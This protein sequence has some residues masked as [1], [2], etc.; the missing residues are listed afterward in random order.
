MTNVQTQPVTQKEDESQN[1]TLQPSPF[2]LYTF[3]RLLLVVA[4]VGAP[5]AFG[6]VVPWAWMALGLVACLALLLWAVGSVQQGALKLVWTPLYLP[7]ALFFILALFQYLGGRTLDRAETRQALVLLA[8]DVALFF[9]AIQLSSTAS[10]ETWRA[11]GLTVLMLAGSLGLFAILQFAAGEQQIYGSVDT[12]GNLLFGPYVNPNHFAGLME[13]LIPVGILYI[14]ERRGKPKLAI[15]A[16]LSLG[17]AVAVASLLL[18]GSRGGLLALGAEVVIAVAVLGRRSA[19]ASPAV[20]PASHLR[21]RTRRLGSGG[22]AALVA[23][24]ILAAVLLFTW[25]DPGFVAQKLGLIVDVGGP[26]W[27]EWAEFR[28]TV[29][30]DSLRMLRDHPIT[31]VGLGNFETAYPPYQSFP[32]E[33]WIDYAHN[34]YV[35]AVAET[36]LVGG[37]LILLALALFL[38]QAFIPTRLQSEIS[39]DTI[40]LEPEDY[41]EGSEPVSRNSSLA[42]GSWIRLGASL[43]CCGMLVHSFFDFNL[44]IPANAAWFAVLAGLA[45]GR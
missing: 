15:L 34:D 1:Y 41:E 44:H 19:G 11:F 14:A 32:S 42:A 18:S 25:V 5:L 37:A 33:L 7:L 13:M 28:K 20:A 40:N 29:A 23:A 21:G 3:C 2:T 9:L 31:G 24:T 12:P 43:G 45:V 17:A 39:N 30:S 26:A 22:L 35:Q 6:A 8:A 16:W 38:R 36:G 27:T 4:L 10:G